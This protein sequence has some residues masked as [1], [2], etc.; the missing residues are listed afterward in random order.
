[1]KYMFYAAVSLTLILPVLAASQQPGAPVKRAVIKKAA[2]PAAA[3]KEP[4]KA[5]DT[6]PM[7]ALKKF[8]GDFVF[9]RHY[10]G[11]N[12]KDPAVKAV[13]LDFFATDCIAC[14]AKLDELQ[15]MARQYAPK[16]LETLLISIDPRPEETL[17]AFLKEKKMSLTVLTDMYRKTLSNY[18][19][20]T[21]P[22][23][24]LIDGDCKAVYVSKKED[25]D[26]SAVA[27]RL[28][29]LTGV[30]PDAAQP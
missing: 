11:K 3:V 13:V 15:A 20:S 21:V 26:Y 22:Q 9:L 30:A 29:R 7:F 4:V 19:F 6:V 2:S 27:S 24:V 28:D 8:G 12:K 25:K 10:C 5:G 1:M 17:P 18:G 16:G 14:V 23:T